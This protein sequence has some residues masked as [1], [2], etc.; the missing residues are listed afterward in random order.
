MHHHTELSFLDE[1]QWVSS[2]HYLKNGWQTAVL[3]WCM[4]QAG[5]PSLY[6]YCAVVLHFSIVASPVG[7]SS[8]HEYHFCQLARQKICVSNFYSTFKVFIRPSLVRGLR[9]RN[10][11]TVFF[12]FRNTL[13][14]FWI[15]YCTSEDRIVLFPINFKFL[16]AIFFP[17]DSLFH[18][19]S[20]FTFSLDLS[21][22]KSVLYIVIQSYPQSFPGLSLHKLNKNWP[23]PLTFLINLLRVCSNNRT[24]GTN[25]RLFF[26]YIKPY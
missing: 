8:N 25:G 2:L 18:W 20:F 3:L 7:H 16:G 24:W 22:T 15:R 4:L 13:Y 9:K 1:Y 21:T 23:V 26:F 12:T 10:G 5:P 14:E 19:A 6:Y 17:L 11:R